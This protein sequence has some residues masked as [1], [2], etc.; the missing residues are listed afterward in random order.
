MLIPLVCF[1]I[2]EFVLSRALSLDNI[3]SSMCI[4]FWPFVHQISSHR[5]YLV[6]V[7]AVHHGAAII[8]DAVVSLLVVLSTST[9][10]TNIANIRTANVFSFSRHARQ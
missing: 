10:M 8:G 7:L 2:F 9:D 5:S 4:G 1:W 3:R 6:V